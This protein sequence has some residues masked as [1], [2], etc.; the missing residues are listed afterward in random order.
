MNTHACMRCDQSVT[1]RVASD[2]KGLAPGRTPLEV[3]G[4]H[5]AWAVRFQGVPGGKPLAVQMVPLSN[6]AE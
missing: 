4:R 3:C 6:S 2:P 5:L 1:F